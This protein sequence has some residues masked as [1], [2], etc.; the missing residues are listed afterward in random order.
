[1]YVA[2]HLDHRP[3]DPEPRAAVGDGQR[4]GRSD[5]PAVSDAVDGRRPPCPGKQNI[6]DW[7]DIAPR[8]GLAYDLFGDASTALKFSWGRY[9]ASV[10]HSLA[11][12]LHTGKAQWQSLSWFDCAMVTVRHGSESNRCATMAELDAISPGLG[13]V[14]YGNSGLDRLG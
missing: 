14:A 5:Q 11:D 12:R 8:I 10:T 13:A 7:T 2:G 1:M 6:P 9:N 3:P 4:H